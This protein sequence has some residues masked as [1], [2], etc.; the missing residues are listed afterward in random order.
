[1]FS[2]SKS[3]CEGNIEKVSQMQV[4]A[5]TSQQKR[6]AHEYVAAALCLT[7]K[8]LLKEYIK[9]WKLPRKSDINVI[10]RQL[11]ESRNS[12]SFVRLKLA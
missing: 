6:A 12:S 11:G 5:R 8:H 7:L 3:A 1:L 2:A 10:E 9:L 4:I